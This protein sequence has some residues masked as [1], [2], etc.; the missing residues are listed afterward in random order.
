VN[1]ECGSEGLLLLGNSVVSY[2]ALEPL[3]TAG[4]F[5]VTANAE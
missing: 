5:Y 4:Y 3:L 1:H 2:A